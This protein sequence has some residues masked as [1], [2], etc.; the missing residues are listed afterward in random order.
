MILLIGVCN[1]KQ[2][3]MIINKEIVSRTEFHDLLS[4]NDWIYCGI[5]KAFVEH[6]NSFNHK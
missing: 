4:E 6:C 5:V 3:I 2:K 1:E